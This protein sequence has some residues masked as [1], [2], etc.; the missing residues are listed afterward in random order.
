MANK[1]ISNSFSPEE[2]EILDF[3][4]STLLRG[5]DARVITRKKGFPGL[6]KKVADMKKRSGEPV[7]TESSSSVEPAAVSNATKE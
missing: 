6:L 1:R 4:F 3:T 5:G 2:I 7:K